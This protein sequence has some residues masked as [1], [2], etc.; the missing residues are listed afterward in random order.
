MVSSL[1]WRV[2][3]QGTSSNAIATCAARHTHPR[4]GS[5][6]VG[7]GLPALVAPIADYREGLCGEGKAREGGM[8]STSRRRATQPSAQSTN[9]GSETM[10]VT[11]CLRSRR[12]ETQQLTE[13]P[14]I[15]PRLCEKCG[16][17]AS[18]R[19][20]LPSPGTRS[21]CAAPMR[22]PPNGLQEQLSKMPP[23]SDVGA[24]TGR[25]LEPATVSYPTQPCLRLRLC[26]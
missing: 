4:Q 2:A 16:L 15:F 5:P 10:H 14:G 17:G 8:A 1:S 18:T 26:L 25:R 6:H 3:W 23:T 11:V 22:A 13:T 12:D 21:D 20:R 24:H 7:I 19:V 9:E